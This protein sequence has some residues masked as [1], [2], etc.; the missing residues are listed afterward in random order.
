[1]EVRKVDLNASLLTDLVATTIRKKIAFR[2]ADSTL[3]TQKQNVNGIK[4]VS[5]R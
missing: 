1:L 2:R 4:S 3:Q 5:G